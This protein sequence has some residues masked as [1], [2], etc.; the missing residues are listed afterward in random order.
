MQQKIERETLIHQLCG[1]HSSSLRR[2]KIKAAGEISW[3]KF[4]RYEMANIFCA[5]LGGGV[6]FMLRKAAYGPL[7]E[8]VGPGLIIGRGVVF[9]HPGRI[10]LGRQVAIDDNVMLDASGAGAEGLHI[11]N[12]VIVSRNCI[13]QGKTGPVALGDRVDIGA[14][15]IITSA[16]GISIDSSVLIAGNCYIGGSQYYANRQDIPIMDQGLYTRGPIEIGKGS[17]L[18]A[19]VIVLDGVRIGKMCIVGAGAVVTKD[20]P[21]HVVAMGIPARFTPNT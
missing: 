17:W 7:F 1:T 6:G 3:F 10:N 18:G 16:G 21:D 11:G 20:L 8:K 9:R 12:Q 5:Q 4:F 14:N 2:Y 13:I 15:T 19:G